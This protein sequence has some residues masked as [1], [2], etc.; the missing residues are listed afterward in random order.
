L[1]ALWRFTY[2][3]MERLRTSIVIL[4]NCNE[5]NFYNIEIMRTSQYAA[6]MMRSYF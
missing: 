2:R 4:L 6:T 3:S 5:I 1:R